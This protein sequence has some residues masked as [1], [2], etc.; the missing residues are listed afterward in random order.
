MKRTCD[1]IG[2]EKSKVTIHACQDTTNTPEKKQFLIKKVHPNKASKTLQNKLKQ[3]ECVVVVVHMCVI[4]SHQPLAPLAWIVNEV[5]FKNEAFFL[6]CAILLFFSYFK[7][8]WE[9]YSQ[10]SASP[11]DSC[12]FE[13]VC[14]RVCA[15]VTVCFFGTNTANTI[16][17]SFR[18]ID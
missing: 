13:V 3:H 15:S 9:Q 10:L 12:S 5:I 8:N 11:L 14:M 7:L 6:C 1:V 18:Q 4:V 2:P 17:I 16:C